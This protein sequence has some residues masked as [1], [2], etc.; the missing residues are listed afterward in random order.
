M[1]VGLVAL[2]VIIVSIG[3]F[4]HRRLPT[5]DEYRRAHGQM[6]TWEQQQ[7]SYDEHQR[8]AAEQFDRQD[9]LLDRIERLVDRL[10]GQY[11]SDQNSAIERQRE[12]N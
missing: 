4:L 10:E 3:G 6:Q 2:I 5:L 9:D 1:F 11:R 7:Q 12:S 8:R